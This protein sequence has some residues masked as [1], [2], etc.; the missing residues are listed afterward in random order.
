MDYSLKNVVLITGASSGIGWELAKLFA[1]EKH[2][3]FLVARDEARLEELKKEIE[4]TYGTRAFIL[5][6]DLTD[7][8][9]LTSLPGA[10]HERGLQVDCLV[11]NA[12][13]GV[14]GAFGETDWQ[15]EQ[16]SILLNSLAPTYLT[17]AFLADLQETRGSILNVISMAA[18]F[19]GPHMAVY[20]ATKAYLSSLSE[21]LGMELQRKNVRVTAFYPG[22]TR[23]GFQKANNMN[24]LS[25][26]RYPT[27]EEIAKL[28]YAAWKKGK[29]RY[30]PG[31]FNKLA[32]WT[33]C[34]VPKQVYAWYLLRRSSL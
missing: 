16:Q 32:Y 28:G 12:G 8:H 6:G 14:A 31:F 4:S 34:L 5:A 27:G 13:M 10:V 3:L 23:T 29:R 33:S 17:K 11:N 25:S 22:P 9:F 18:F 1:K 30:L 7:Q 15:K 19:P 21:S 26:R 2:D 24:E 20:F